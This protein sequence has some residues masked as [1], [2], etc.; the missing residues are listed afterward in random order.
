MKVNLDNATI[1]DVRTPQEFASGHI[2]GA[3]NVPLDA[4]QQSLE[5]IKGM[6]K[7]IVAYC[8]S[9]N[10]SGMAVAILKQYGISDAINGGGIDDLKQQLS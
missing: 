3:K 1:I 5:E 8:Q 6:Q 7:P 9:G 10:R 2:D 4:L